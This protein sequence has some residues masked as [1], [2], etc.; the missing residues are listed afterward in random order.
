ILGNYF[1]GAVI[2]ALINGVVVTSLLTIVGVPYSFALGIF[3]A[4]MS[5][6]PYFGVLISF[7]IGFIISLFSGLSGL[8][9]IWIPIIYFGENLL[10]S[11]IFYPKIVGAQIGLHPI[12]LMLSLFVFS[13]FFGFIGLL[14]AVPST[15]ILVLFFEKYLENRNLQTKLSIREEN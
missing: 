13:L 11:S 3:S 14:I 8:S 15:S 6:I 9:L 5:L 10:E 2:V 1:R 4:L 7:T 12:L